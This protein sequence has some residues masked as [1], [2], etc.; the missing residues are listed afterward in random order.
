MDH[1]L[2]ELFLVDA[3]ALVHVVG[4]FCLFYHHLHHALH[5]ILHCVGVVL[6]LAHHLFHAV[7]LLLLGVK[8][9]LLGLLTSHLGCGLTSRGSELRLHED[10]LGLGVRHVD[11]MHLHE[12]LLIKSDVVHGVLKKISA[13]CLLLLDHLLHEL[14]VLG[15][16]ALLE[17][18]S[19]LLEELSL[20]LVELGLSVL[21]NDKEDVLVVREAEE[22]VHF[23]AGCAEGVDLL[24]DLGGLLGRLLVLGGE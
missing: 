2:V 13:G 11:L 8:E 20:L 1:G 14:L 17:E 4:Q 15:G 16:L 6:L 21:L 5:R 3:V 18:L 23:L 9:D 24:E 10:L 12:L 19:S 22:A 7:E